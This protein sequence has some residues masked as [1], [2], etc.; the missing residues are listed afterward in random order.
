MNAR[1]RFLAV[2]NGQPVDRMPFFEEEI[3]PDVLEAWHR[4]GL[5]ASVTAAN[6][7]AYLGLDRLGYIHTR[8]SP[9]EGAITGPESL[10]RIIRHYQE[11]PVK[12][13]TAEFWQDKAAEYQG[14]DLP[15]GVQG[16]N[17]FQLPLFPPDPANEH[18]EWDNLINLYIQLKDN[19][20]TVAEALSFIADYYI[21]IVQLAL[22]YLDFDYVILREPIASPIGPVISPRDFVRLVLPQYHKL[23]AAYRRMNVPIILFSSISNVRPLLPLV[24]AAGV[25]GLMITQIMNAGVDY[26]Q[27]GRQFPHVGLIGGIESV[28]LL[29]STEAVVHEVKK[30]AVP[31]L[32]R[33]HWLPALD[34]NARANVPYR[35]F[36]A[37]RQTLLQC[38]NDATG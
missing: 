28:T 23:V 22:R 5:P 27:I 11:H 10:W 24:V 7:R 1:D 13:L 25:D 33:G 4:Q 30:K 16:W 20:E 17:G 32:K 35:R 6:Y 18:N 12:Y 21:A 31:L 26:V 8:F 15:L 2:L 9:V 14:R 3:R 19:P 34:D 29:E 38:C 36:L 37:Y